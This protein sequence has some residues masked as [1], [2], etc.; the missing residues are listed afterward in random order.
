MGLFG[1]M[2]KDAVVNG[3]T[4]GI[5]STQFS[6]MFGIGGSYTQFPPNGIDV[7][8]S[9]YTN[10]PFDG[11]PY[12]DTLNT[13]SM[14]PNTPSTN[15]SSLHGK[16]SKFSGTTSYS[17]DNATY[18]N[19]QGSDNFYV[20]IPS[21]GYADYINERNIWIKHL[22]NGL[23]EQNWLYFRIFFDF[24]TNHGLFGGILNNMNKLGTNSAYKYLSLLNQNLFSI[25]NVSS[26]K[27]SL[28]IFVRT[29]STINT[30]SGWMFKRISNINNAANPNIDEFS[31]EKSINL[32]LNPDTIDF[33]LTTALSAYKYACFDD[34]NTKEIIPENLRK[35]DMNVVIF[36]LPIKYIH[37]PV[38]N[39]SSG[40]V[41]R[42]EYKKTFDSSN[43]NNM[44]SMKIL[45]F[46]NCEIDK[47]SIGSYIPGSLTNDSP[48]QLG[49]NSIKITYDKMLETMVNEYDQ[50]LINSMGIWEYGGTNGT[51]EMLAQ[52]RD[53]MSQG[54]ILL[55]AS[56]SYITYKLN[57]KFGVNKNFILGNIYGQDS[58][59][60]KSSVNKTYD[61]T[62]RSSLTDY[63]KA[64]VG[65]IKGEK[66][67]M[68]DIGYNLL[69]KLLG[70]SYRYGESPGNDGTGTVLN[71][72]GQFGIGSKVFENKLE[73]IKYGGLAKNLG[74]RE[75]RLNTID[76]ANN[77]S[78]GKFLQQ[79]IHG[80]N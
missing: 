77:F 59:V 63:F 22:S 3:I 41:I 36:S 5:R 66:N 61:K 76:K 27:K 55:T 42:K 35:F 47:E 4:Q 50:I 12:S 29:L 15:S 24:D 45:T 31:K 16:Q 28:E 18:V 11:N 74:A 34:Y 25:E 75:N 9:E 14:A 20:K 57:E 23:D 60:Y 33:R 58:K 62:S 49:K 48:F 30:L 38:V 44:M 17:G 65:V 32:E 78:V 7:N 69:Y 71:G 37:T 2:I 68:L 52:T 39:D 54:D 80:R 8:I 46:Y 43:P 10:N 70:S 67:L 19:D 21:W 56:D 64:K 26:R 73:R 6:N 53:E 79:K 51:L 13:V 1:D 72:Q 40:D